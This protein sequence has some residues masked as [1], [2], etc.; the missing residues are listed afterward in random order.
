MTVPLRRPTSDS[1]SITQGALL[2]LNSIYR[3]GFN[4]AKA[5]IMLLDLR[6][7]SVE[8]HELDFD[9]GPTDRGPL[10]GALDRINDRYGRGTMLLASAGNRGA[11]RN[12]VMKQERRTPRYMTHW[13]DMPTARA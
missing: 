7:G 12:W 13:G 3:P 4:Y 1:A 8:Q 5:G 10:M 11:R 9:E 6:P 2:G